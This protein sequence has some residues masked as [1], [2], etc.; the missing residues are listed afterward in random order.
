MR[1]LAL[2]LLLSSALFADSENGVIERL[3][4]AAW[5]PA[6]VHAEWQTSGA[7]PAIIAQHDDW[8]LADPH[9]TRL[10]GGLVL[11]L[12]RTNLSGNVERVALSGMLRIFGPSLMTKHVVNSG[13][14]ISPADVEAVQAEWTYLS[15]GPL[16]EANLST[17]SVATRSL[18][19]GRALTVRDVKAAPRIR[20]GQSVQLV[21][22]EGAVRVRLTGRALQDGAVGERVPVTADMGTS[23][24]FE[25]RVLADGTVQLVR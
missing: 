12:E 1:A 6:R 20:R 9:S 23:R 7:A 8:R 2:I 5:L 25:G 16:Q 14:V 11:T 19:P 21:Y 24:K 15:D 13:A 22:E 4:A 10:A 17:P 3:A 18:V